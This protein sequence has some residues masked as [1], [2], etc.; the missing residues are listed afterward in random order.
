MG[1]FIGNLQPGTTTS[2]LLDF[3]GDQD[4]ITDIE[5]V[6]RRSEQGEVRFGHVLFRSEDDAAKAIK[7]QQKKDL[8]GSMVLVREYIDRANSERRSADLQVDIDEE[9][10]RRGVDRRYM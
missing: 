3:M 10:D 2:D 4:G 1:I 6:K 5:I 9:S 7:L 8:Y